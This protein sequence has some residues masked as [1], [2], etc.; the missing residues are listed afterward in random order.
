MACPQTHLFPVNTEEWY[1]DV[2]KRTQGRCHYICILNPRP[3]EVSHPNHHLPLLQ[4]PQCLSDSV[5]SQPWPARLLHSHGLPAMSVWIL[6]RWPSAML[7]SF[8]RLQDRM[9]AHSTQTTEVLCHSTPDTHTAVL[10]MVLRAFKSAPTTGCLLG[11]EYV[12][13]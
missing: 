11:Y 2:Y 6:L 10:R 4:L 12:C 1:I 9:F 13:T 3:L 7:L 8:V 5:W